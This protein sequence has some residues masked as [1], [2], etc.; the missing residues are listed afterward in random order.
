MLKEGRLEK[1]LSF[2]ITGLILAGILIFGTASAVN[3]FVHSATNSSPVIGATIY[4]IAEVDINTGER[5][6][7]ENLTLEI[8]DSRNCTF[9]PNGTEISG[10]ACSHITVTPI[11]NSPIGWGYGYMWGYG[12]GNNVTSSV[13]QNTSF[14]TYY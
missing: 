5:I 3:V 6:P 12:F 10:N 7:I 8:N 13:T 14:G 4:F 11:N 1:I 9:Y 2:V